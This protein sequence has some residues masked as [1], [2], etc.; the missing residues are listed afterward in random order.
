MKTCQLDGGVAER[1][2]ELGAQ[3]ISSRKG[4]PPGFDCYL[5][6]TSGEATAG[7]QAMIRLKGDNVHT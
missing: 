4:L 2:E 5:K 3:E 1:P 7:A 6:I